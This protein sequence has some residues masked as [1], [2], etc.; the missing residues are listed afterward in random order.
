MT[1]GAMLQAAQEGRKE[2]TGAVLKRDWERNATWRRVGD[3][4][5]EQLLLHYKT[6][7]YMG[8]LFGLKNGIGKSSYKS[9]R[10]THEA[11][12]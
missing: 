10:Q 9:G 12:S 2:E 1:L 7:G 4:R 5:Q 3:M 11:I 8:A 6:E